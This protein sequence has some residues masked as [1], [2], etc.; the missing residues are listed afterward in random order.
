ME[1]GWHDQ[2]WC[3]LDSVPDAG[4]VSSFTYNLHGPPNTFLWK[5]I[6]SRGFFEIILSEP[7]NFLNRSL[8]VVRFHGFSGSKTFGDRS[9]CFLVTDMIGSFYF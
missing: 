3:G 6:I 4:F 2:I 7:A 9:L 1:T 8:I 5:S